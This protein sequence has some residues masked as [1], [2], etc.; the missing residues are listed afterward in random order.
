V[1]RRFSQARP[2]A[3]WVADFTYVAT[4]SG[5]VYVGFVLDAYSRRILG[6]RAST[7]MRTELVLDALEQAIWTRAREGVY[8]LSGLVCHNDAELPAAVGVMNHPVDGLAG[9]RA[10]PDAHLQGVEGQVGAQAARQLPAHDAAE[11]TSM[12]KAACTQPAKV[13]Q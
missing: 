7:S 13:R 2:G 6:W 8:D 11:K 1:Q 9:M 4:W 10:G 12:T 3:V 5:T